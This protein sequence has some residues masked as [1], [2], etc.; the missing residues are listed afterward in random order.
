[1]GGDY[2]GSRGAGPATA[3]YLLGGDVGKKP[4][5]GC[6]LVHVFDSGQVFC[7]LK[8]RLFNSACVSKH[9]KVTGMLKFADVIHRVPF[10]YL[11]KVI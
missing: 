10:V 2:A 11:E 6:L 1:M 5:S 7:I 9:Q 8:I 4:T 3:A